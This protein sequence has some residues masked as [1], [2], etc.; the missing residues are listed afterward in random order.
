MINFD[1]H[2]NEQTGTPSC[3]PGVKSKYNALQPHYR[4]IVLGRNVSD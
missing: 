1:E 4:H 3:F 2:H